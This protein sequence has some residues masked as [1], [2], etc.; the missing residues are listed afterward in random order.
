MNET[1][2][3]QGN[4]RCIARVADTAP[5][6][7]R[8]RLACCQEHSIKINGE[9]LCEICIAIRFTSPTSSSGSQDRERLD[10]A[11]G[12]YVSAPAKSWWEQMREIQAEVDVIY[13][14]HP[15]PAKRLRERYTED[16]RQDFA[17]DFRPGDEI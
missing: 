2:P 1:S 11:P 6:C 3:C 13:A 7:A 10:P 16:E 9:L 8:C 17:D 14:R 12:V 15:V 4:D 5:K